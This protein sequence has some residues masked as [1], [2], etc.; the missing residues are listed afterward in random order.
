MSEVRCRQKQAVNGIIKITTKRRPNRAHIYPIQSN[1]SGIS[2]PEGIILL[3][4]RSS[5]LL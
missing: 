3:I 2:M 5:Y 4:R 1:P